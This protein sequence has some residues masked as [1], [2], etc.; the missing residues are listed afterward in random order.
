[1]NPAAPHGRNYA[2]PPPSV[3]FVVSRLGFSVSQALADGLKP[4]GIDPQH[5]GLLRALLFSE[6]QS[7]RGSEPVSASRR[8]GWWPWSTIWR[9]GGPS[10]GSSI[11]PT[12]APTPL[13]L[14]RRATSSS[15]RPCRSRI[16]R[17][18]PSLRKP[19]GCR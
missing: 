4:L 13:P 8:T 12:G 2:D 17:R 15:R 9:N 3:A 5:F 16:L 1:M 18:S 6:G 7:Q 11:P 19:L 14:L 10:R